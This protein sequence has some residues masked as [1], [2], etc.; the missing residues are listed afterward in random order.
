MRRRVFRGHT[1]SSGT[2]VGFSSNGKFIMSGDSQGQLHVW[3]FQSTKVQYDNPNAVIG[4]R[5]IAS[6]KRT[7]MDLV[8]ALP[9]ILWRQV[10]L[11]HVDGMVW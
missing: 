6:F 9:G 3:D 1:P 4:S 10:G 11:L 8:S 5:Y 7:I 2:E